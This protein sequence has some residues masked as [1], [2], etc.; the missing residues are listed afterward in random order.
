MSRLVAASL[1]IM[2]VRP[3]LGRS[4]DSQTWTRR[5]M[6]GHAVFDLRAGI[7]ALDPSHPYIC[8][9]GS[10]TSWLSL[11]ACGTGSGI[12]HQSPAPDMAHFRARA[13]VAALERGRLDGALL[14]G[15]GIT[16]VQRTADRPGF[17]FGRARNEEQVEAAGPET[18]LSVKGRYWI[19]RAG[20][21]YLSGDVNA[22]AA[23]IP[24]AQTVLGGGGPLVP[25][26]S[27][28]VGVGF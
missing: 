28:T 9:E 5:P 18:S 1:L 8:A 4:V 14:L 27:F 17:I 3:A 22:G 24:A 15:A 23:A 6:A 25:F 11:E 20:R 12:L 7:H 16:E 2:L 21:T 26:A 13:R 10:P 19:D